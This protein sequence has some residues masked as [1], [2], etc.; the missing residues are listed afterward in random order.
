MYYLRN[1]LYGQVNF[2]VVH[3]D[4]FNISLPIKNGAIWCVL[5]NILLKF[6]KKN[7]CKN[8]HFL[9]KNNRK[10]MRTQYLGVLEH[11]PYISC[12]LCNLQDTRLIQNFI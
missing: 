7:N 4:N 10:C 12:Q 8:I 6:C 2:N 9:Y 1:E 11:T 5:E 3:L